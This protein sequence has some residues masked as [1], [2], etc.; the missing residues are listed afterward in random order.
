M[1]KVYN[2]GNFD[3]HPLGKDNFYLGLE[4]L[5]L[6]MFY[7]QTFFGFQENKTHTKYFV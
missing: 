3:G 4:N 1:A 7:L 2:I 5:I 6:Q